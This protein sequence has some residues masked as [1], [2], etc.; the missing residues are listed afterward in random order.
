MGNNGLDLDDLGLG[1]EE[2]RAHAGLPGASNC[3]QSHPVGPLIGV[4]CKI[5]F[6]KV[7]CRLEETPTAQ[8]P[9][10]DGI[11][12]LPFCSNSMNPQ[13]GK[14]PSGVLLSP[15][16]VPGALSPAASCSRASEVGLCMC[17]GAGSGVEA[18]LGSGL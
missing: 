6:E 5:A 13:P 16:P 9:R 3:M 14:F 4:L 12:A 18:I 15:T 10:V 8:R 1:E 11:G 2:G 17:M 7:L